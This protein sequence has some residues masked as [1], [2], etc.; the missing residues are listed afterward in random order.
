M[1]WK[2]FLNSHTIIINGHQLWAHSI[3]GTLHNKNIDRMSLYICDVHSLVLISIH[4]EYIFIAENGVVVG[5]TDPGVRLPGFQSWLSHLCNVWPW[6]NYWSSIFSFE[7]RGKHLTNLLRELKG[8]IG[9]HLGKCHPLASTQQ[10][11]G[12]VMISIID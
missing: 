2:L 7:K 10:I 1:L 3:L 4:C 5:S 8:I 12:T 6:A 9:T 11:K